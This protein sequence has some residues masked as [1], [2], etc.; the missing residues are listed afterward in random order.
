M[1]HRTFPFRLRSNHGTP[2]R[3]THSLLVEFLSE[4]GDWQPQHPSLSTPGFR[5]YLLSLVLCHHHYL[6]AKAQEKAIPL[7]QVQADFTVITSADWIIEQVSG[8]FRLELDPA[9]PAEERARADDAA[10]AF[11]SERMKLCP[12][13]RNLP[14]TV[15]KTITLEVA[16]PGSERL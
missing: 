12:V 8:S 7:L 10:I 4:A 9:E 2:D 6:V 13:S 5:L 11:I 16:S 1:N 15:K 3:A 14:A